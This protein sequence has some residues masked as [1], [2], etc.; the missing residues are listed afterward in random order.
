MYGYQDSDDDERSKQDGE[1]NTRPP[2]GPLEDLPTAWRRQFS[3][4]LSRQLRDA[5]TAQ[6]WALGGRQPP[7]PPPTPVQQ[8]PGAHLGIFPTILAVNDRR[9]QD[10]RATGRRWPGVNVTKLEQALTCPESAAYLGSVCVAVGAARTVALARMAAQ[11]YLDAAQ[12]QSAPLDATDIYSIAYYGLGLTISPLDCSRNPETLAVYHQAVSHVHLDWTLFR[13]VL[14]PRGEG[15]VDP[16][17]WRRVFDSS[18]TAR[19]LLSWI[20]ATHL[21]TPCDTP[22][23]LGFVEA[24]SWQ[25]LATQRNPD[26]LG[27]LHR[28]LVA[29]QTLLA[30]IERVWDQV[31]ALHLP[32]KVT[33]G[34]RRW[35]AV[36]R[37]F[38]PELPTAPLRPQATTRPDGRSPDDLDVLLVETL[39]EHNGCPPLLIERA[40]DGADELPNW[41]AVSG[42]LLRELPQLSV[43]AR[44]CVRMWEAWEQ[45]HTHATTPALVSSAPQTIM[46]AQPLLRRGVNSGGLAVAVAEPPTAVAPQVEPLRAYLAL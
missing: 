25:G 23:H 17:V 19:F 44:Q 42:R 32:V 11:R 10:Y 12:R 2:S 29:V 38:I 13:Q 35:R 20:V 40:L 14:A 31:M 41:A 4:D 30:P 34:D 33:R 16:L 39:A 45:A 8:A 6:R 1:E 7:L 15:V 22:I 36:L 3:Q 27:R 26:T 5:S 9:H 24:Q 21:T 43:R 46:A 28:A 37:A 18:P